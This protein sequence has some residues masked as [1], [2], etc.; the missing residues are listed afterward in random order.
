MNPIVK[1]SLRYGVL[2]GMIGSA[3]LIALYYIDRHPFLIP[4]YLD[5]RI[6]L[7]GVFIFF[8]L[9][10]IRD[11]H[12]NGILYFWQGFLAS[13]FFTVVYALIASTIV[14]VFTYVV[15]AFL[16]DY[17]RLQTEVLQSLSPEVI[18][19]IGKDA[20]KRNLDLLPSTT[21]LQLG[22]THL[23]QSFLI[24]LFISVILSVTLRRQ[25]QT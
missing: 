2:A 12:F 10:E 18:E 13:F 20:Y 8:A 16:T 1:V 11:Y 25:P 6:V 4:V 23:A 15:P 3:L 22:A 5:F 17:I 9:R 24:S 21:P 14:V 7:F 19:S